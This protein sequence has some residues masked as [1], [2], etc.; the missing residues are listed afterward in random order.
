MRKDIKRKVNKVANY[1]L[2]FSLVGTGVGLTTLVTP[3][4]TVL[5]AK[6]HDGVCQVET[7]NGELTFNAQSTTVETTKPVDLLAI[8]D[9]SGS[10]E[11]D[12]AHT[13]YATLHALLQSLPDDSRVMFAVYSTN[14]SSSYRHSGDNT[15]SRLLT[16]DEAVAMV[17]M[18]DM[19][20]PAFGGSGDALINEIKVNGAGYGTMGSMYG[21]LFAG[22]MRPNYIHSVIQITDEWVEAESIDEM[23]AS[24]AKKNAKT[25]MSVVI[26]KS[27]DSKSV[28]EM[29]RV[30]HPNIYVTG[31]KGQATINKE[32]IAQFNT[33]ATEKA[34][35]TARINVTAPQ[36]VTLREVKLVAPDG[37][38]EVLPITS[39]SVNVEKTLAKDGNYKVKVKADGLVPEN[40]KVV[41]TVN[42]ANKEVGKSEILFEGCKDDVKGTDEERTRVNIDFKTKYVDDAN[43]MTGT[44][45]VVTDGVIGIKEIIKTWNTINGKRVGEPKIVENMLQGV[46]DKVIARGTKGFDREVIKQKIPFD[47][48]YIDDEKLE[49]GKTKVVTEG[50]E[51][52]KEITKVYVTQS[53]KRVGEPTVTE[54]V[55]KPKVDKVIARGTQQPKDFTYRVL[56]KDGKVLVDTTKVA[57]GYIGNEYKLAEVPKLEGYEVV[58]PEGIKLDGVFNGENVNIDFVAYKL[59][60]E[61]SLNLVDV[62]GK[63][64]GKGQV[65]VEKGKR[66]GV[67]F[68]GKVEKEFK[69][70][71]RLYRLTELKLGDTKLEGLEFTGKVTEVAQKYVAQYKEVLPAPVKVNFVDENGKELQKPVNL[72]KEA[73]RLDG[74]YTYTP[75]KRVK[76]GTDE[77][78]LVKVTLDGKEV[79]EIKG[80]FT[81]KEQVYKVEYK[82]VVKPAPAKLPKTSA[83]DDLRGYGI[84]ATLLGVLGFLGF[85]RFK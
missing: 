5:A 82:K 46:I 42:I 21:D 51:G 49:S 33:T 47:T 36:G 52:E 84:V 50:V 2:A 44:E 31:N 48:K 43:L 61:V 60:D 75:E 40:R 83:S 53:G 10:M 74:E 72:L 3:T 26:N 37:K 59:G 32:V 35:P 34:E 23:F 56:D 25:F 18:L 67:D 28:R 65:L 8:I 58:T 62:K 1:S 20:Y 68:S 45:K 30:G 12:K 81:E 24:W 79:K 27:A 70:G 55:V 76:V 66:V 11:N 29:Q 78:A 54:K 57:Q 17:K 63:V 73:S 16:K 41:T 64:L 38:E 9:G 7:K 85:R 19:G 77:Y 71:D 14:E 6:N 22:V 39:N 69:D 4:H 13:L 15:V 80:K